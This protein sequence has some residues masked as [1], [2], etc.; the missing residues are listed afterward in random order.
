MYPTL[1]DQ[2]VKKKNTNEMII[3]IQHYPSII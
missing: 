3:Q 1:Y 2:K